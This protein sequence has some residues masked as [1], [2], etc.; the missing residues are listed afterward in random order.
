[1]NCTASIVD[2]L[3]AAEALAMAPTAAHLEQIE[4]LL[5]ASVAAAG[6]IQDPV[7]AVEIGNRVR[8]IG[9]LL[10]GAWQLR[11]GL[12]RLAAAG[13]A[14]YSPAGAPDQDLGKTARPGSLTTMA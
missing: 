11:L 12:A 3:D 2:H 4:P 10:D 13:L 7:L 9:K 1:M 8:R 14:G 5:A 6:W